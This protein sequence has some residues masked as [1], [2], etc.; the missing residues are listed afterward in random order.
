M[1]HSTPDYSVFGHAS[2]WAGV[3]FA[4]SFGLM[5]VVAAWLGW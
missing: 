3:I 4:V 1:K 5:L 2:A